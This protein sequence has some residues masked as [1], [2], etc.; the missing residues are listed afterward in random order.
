MS[1]PEAEPSGLRAWPW[2]LVLSLVALGLM[3]MFLRNAAPTPAS[4]TTTADAPAPM[5]RNLP[6]NQTVHTETAQSTNR[7]AEPNAAHCVAESGSAAAYQQLDA[8]QW[9]ELHRWQ[10]ERGLSLTVLQTD[11][12]LK[13]EPSDYHQYD[14]ATLR[15]LAEQGDADAKYFYAQQLL[16]TE[17]PTAAYQ[18]QQE[19]RHLL[20]QQLWR[21]AAVQGH[22]PAM[23]AIAESYQQ[24][25]E[26][27]SRPESQRLEAGVQWLAWRYL[28]DWRLGILPQRQN[29]AE[30]IHEQAVTASQQLQQW[31]QQRRQQ[32]GLLPLDNRVPTGIVTVLLGKPKN[33]Q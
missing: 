19:D 28:A 26:D 20:V 30:T 18:N 16:A 33:C 24:A 9:R 21:E 15:A 29:V 12:S 1:E 31:L 14:A 22:V 27:F 4:M 8:V 7:N 17:A 5:A 23:L 10:S 2:L 6:S 32:Q 25:S 13:Q 11:N 3:A